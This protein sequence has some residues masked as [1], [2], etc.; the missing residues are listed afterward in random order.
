MKKKSSQLDPERIE[1]L[2]SIGFQWRLMECEK[3]SWDDRFEALKKFKVKNGHLQIPGHHPDFGNWPG[4]QKSQYNRYKE[5][6]KSKITKEKV[7]RLIAIGFLEPPPNSPSSAKAS[8]QTTDT[9]VRH[10]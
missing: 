6:K 5:G 8:D 10:R 9:D 4:Y 2:N 3:V 1:I 7:D